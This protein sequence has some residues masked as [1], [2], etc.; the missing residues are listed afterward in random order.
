M[1]I[2]KSTTVTIHSANGEVRT[3]M[4]A[5]G[6]AMVAAGIVSGTNTTVPVDKGKSRRRVVTP[7][8]KPASVEELTQALS[9]LAPSEKPSVIVTAKKGDYSNVT[10]FVTKE[11]I[12]GKE[13]DGEFLTIRRNRL[14][15]ETGEHEP[16]GYNFKFDKS[17]PYH[18]GTK[19]GTPWPTLN[20][21][22]DVDG[23]KAKRWTRYVPESCSAAMLTGLREAFPGATLVIEGKRVKL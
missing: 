8:A 15:A 9:A 1:S 17:I 22:V 10:I 14:N 6:A 20:A 5:L 23:V 21:V 4:G 16:D 3:N 2:N 13:S 7:A 18:E 12:P 19:N 11:K